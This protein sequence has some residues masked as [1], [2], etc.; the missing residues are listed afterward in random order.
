MIIK[1][2]FILKDDT[3]ANPSGAS[4]DAGASSSSDQTSNQTDAN[5][6]GE[7]SASQQVD[8]G[9]T[10]KT[11]ENVIQDV[12]KKSQ[13]SS[14][15][16]DADSGVQKSNATEEGKEGEE[17][18][19][20]EEESRDSE[21]GKE[22]EE[23]E[24]EL[25]AGKPVPY[26]RFTEVNTKAKQFEGKVKELEPLAEAQRGV[27]E[28]CMQHEITPEQFRDWMD[29]AALANVDPKQALEKLKPVLDRLQGATGDKLPA[30]LQT[31]VDNG[32]ISLDYAKR[33]VQAESKSKYSDRQ[34]Q[35][36]QE[37]VF[38]EKQQQ[39]AQTMRQSVSSWIDTKK[40]SDP[41]FAPKASDKAPHGKY[42]LFMN[43][44]AAQAKAK[45][46][47]IKSADDLIKVAEEAYAAI[48]ATL[49]GFQ[50][51][52]TANSKLNSNRSSSTVKPAP[53]TVEEAM[54]NAA[55]KH[56]LVLTPSS[57]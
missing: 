44:F 1:L 21:Q 13:S 8:Q 14:D 32:D 50:P 51:K 23:K 2:P 57:N 22:G 49:K 16:E 5:Q 56:G 15:E 18:G 25:E 36:T 40:G 47:E 26:E 34:V 35:K 37:Q 39:F 17:S 27:A 28:H 52:I 29:I 30:E 33:L 31:A 3:D 10:E 12:F 19:K 11:L 6:G 4:S 42:E 24:V 41:D 53:K 54:A 45:M 7:S 9:K 46:N 38:A 43:E 48:N 55:K 20:K